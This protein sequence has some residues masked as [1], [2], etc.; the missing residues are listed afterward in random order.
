MLGVLYVTV[1]WVDTIL[2]RNAV[3]CTLIYPA[4][5]SDR[6]TLRELCIKQCFT[7]G[8]EQNNDQWSVFNDVP[9]ELVPAI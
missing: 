3:K 2:V 5:L 7:R 9:S 1:W 6:S 4:W 8:K